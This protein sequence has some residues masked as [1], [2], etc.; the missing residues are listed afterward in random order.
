MKLAQESAL[1][2]NS[3][4]ADAAG[5]R[6][7]FEDLGLG[8]QWQPQEA[9]NAQHD[10]RLWVWSFACELRQTPWPLWASVSPTG[11]QEGHHT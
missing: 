11:R 7:H 4:G 2:I 3:R 5:P 9:L 8:F 10:R 1:P 6:L